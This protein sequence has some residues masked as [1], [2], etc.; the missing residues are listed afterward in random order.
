MPASLANT[1][2]FTRNS[3]Q[4]RAT[5]EQFRATK[6]RLETLLKIHAHLKLRW[7][8]LFEEKST[9]MIFLYISILSNNM[10]L[11]PLLPSRI[12]LPKITVFIKNSYFYCISVFV[13]KITLPYTFENYF[14]SIQWVSSF[15]V[16]TY[17]QFC[18]FKLFKI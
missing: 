17:F 12:Q 6:F 8:S 16:F 9:K 11:P 13:E 3:A 14:Y 4:F 7:Q 10:N 18:N 15:F 2:G 1:S 5:W